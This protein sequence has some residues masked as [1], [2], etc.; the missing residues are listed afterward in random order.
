MGDPQEYEDSMIS[1]RP[2]MKMEMN[3][4]LHRLVEVQYERND[5][6]FDR[7]DFRVRGDTVEVI[8]AG[9]KEDGIRIEFFGDEIDRITEFRVTDGHALRTVQHAMIFPATHYATSV[10][11]REEAL[12]QIERDMEARAAE[13][14]KEEKPLERERILQRTR[15]DIEM[16]R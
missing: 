11:G 5:I 10:S 6:G 15:Y 8:P 7:G 1:L 3:T 16:L 9:S 12:Q 14:E 4:L 13:F 2:G